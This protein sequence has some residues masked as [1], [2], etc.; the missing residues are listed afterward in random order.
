MTKMVMSMV[1]LVLLLPMTA[2]A[3]QKGSIELKSVSEVEVTTTNAK[4]EKEV[5]RVEAAAAKVI[6]GD[7]VIFTTQYANI[8]RKPAEN[9]VIT[10][11][12]SEHVVYVENSAEGQ[13]MK[14]E[15][16]ADQGKRYAAPDKLTKTDAKGVSKR[17]TARDYT[18]IRWTLGKPLAPDGKGS[19]TFRAMVK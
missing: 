12:V 19:V 4:G 18:H 17:A 3:Q 1:L 6:P 10:N 15:F 8:D 2:A 14:I 11:P 16:S 13:G 5:K 9:V 7:V